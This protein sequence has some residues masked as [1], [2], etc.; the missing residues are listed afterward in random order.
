MKT[1]KGEGHMMD[2]TN[3]GTAVVSGEVI[4]FTW[5]VGVASVDMAA[6]AKGA[7]AVCGVHKLAKEAALAIAQGAKV[8]WDSTNKVVTTTSS[9]NTP[10]GY[11][12]LAAL[13]ADSKVEVKLHPTIA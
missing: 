11:A 8:Y 3:G 13:A 12:W 10:M 6:N 4:P 9:G 1:F 5:G 7:V 2:Y